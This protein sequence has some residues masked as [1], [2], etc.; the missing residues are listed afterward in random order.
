MV[1]LG[2]VVDGATELLEQG[3]YGFLETSAAGTAAAREAFA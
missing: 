1:A 3:T 2:A